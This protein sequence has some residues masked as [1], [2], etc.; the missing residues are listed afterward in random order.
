MCGIAG[1]LSREDFSDEYWI[2]NLEA[3]ASSLAHRGPDKEG[4][5]FDRSQGI[6]FSHRRLSILDL[7]ETGNQPMHSACNNYVITFNGEIYNHLNIR[8]RLEE[9]NYI[10]SW[11][12]TSD[13]ETFIS[14]FASW[15]IKK[16][17]KESRGMFAFSVWDKR[18]KE[19]ILGRDRFGEKPLYY[20]WNGNIFLFGSELKSIKNHVSFIGEIDKEAL[21]L[22]LQNSYVPCP[23]SIYKN[24]NKLE[25][26]TI[27]KISLNTNDI[28]KE[29]FWD[30]QQVAGSVRNSLNLSKK[31][32][33]RSL[34]NL[35][36]DVVE[37]QMI[38]DVP[39][40]GFL[41]GGIDSSLILAI[42]QSQSS[43]AVKSF[44]IGFSEKEF[45]ESTYASNVAKYLG[46]DHTELIVSPNDL[47]AVVPEL[48][49]IYDEPFAD[50][51]QVP[52]FLLSSLASKKVKVSLS[53]D[54]GDEMFAGYNRHRFANN[55]WPKLNYVPLKLRK[56]IATKIIGKSPEDLKELIKLLPLSSHKQ[57]NL[58]SLLIKIAKVI[59]T[60]NITNYYENLIYQTDQSHKILNE[61]SHFNTSDWVEN[62]NTNM[63]ECSDLEKVMLM[64]TINY[65]PDDILV[66]VDRASMS[67]SLETR[68]PFLDPRVF[69][70]AWS[71]PSSLKING[72]KTKFILREV[73]SNYIP[74]EMIERPK[75]GFGIPLDDWLRGPLKDWADALLN[76]ELINSEKLLNAEVV[77]KLWS[78]H[79]QGKINNGP[80]LWNILMFQLWLKDE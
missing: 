64:D 80:L 16:T 5:W 60:E 13:T 75:K 3:M 4:I 18:K 19:L 14:A 39:L 59:D 20:G 71:L 38:S 23:K 6:G 29:K 58:G 1:F 79:N 77:E 73:L 28:K 50:S 32:A 10:T 55:I 54:G 69:R 72:S 35:L 40:G 26:S 12:G 78:D 44:T 61:G 68:A 8:K 76:K 22:Y 53:G 9:E 30:T 2:N 33:I 27:A 17:L 42:M 51:S 7:T 65:L 41:S 36:N 47:L 70:Y 52:T 62:L 46:T 34:D 56:F 25:P 63:G 66:K 49:K 45:D 11:R 67:V 74:K 15:G 57:N 31:E 21:S 48:S 37:E 24:I 43:K